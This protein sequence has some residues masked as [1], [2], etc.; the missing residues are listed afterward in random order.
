VCAGIDRKPHIAD[1]GKLVPE[2]FEGGITFNNVV[3]SYPSRPTQMVL[4]GV[5]FHVRC[6]AVPRAAV[7]RLIDTLGVPRIRAP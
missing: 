6:G 2:K 4:N 5:S 3:F 1:D 7:P